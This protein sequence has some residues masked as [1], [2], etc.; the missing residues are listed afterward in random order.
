MA[1]V[2]RTS[3]VVEFSD[4][5]MAGLVH[6]A[7]FFTFMEAAEHEFLRALGLSVVMEWEGQR[8]SFPRVHASCDY[9]R[10]ARFEDVLTVTVVVANVGRTSIT[11]GFRFFK[12]QEPVATGQITAVC[13]RHTADGLL[14]PFEIPAG[15]RARLE[16]TDTAPGRGAGI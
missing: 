6:F 9:L 16:Q 11:Y 14:E 5:D 3:R 15:L 10:P 13:C 7:R 1:A 12:G 2:F 8:L 4:T